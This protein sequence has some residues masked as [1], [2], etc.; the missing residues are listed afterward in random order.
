M[1]SQDADAGRVV[2]Q[3]LLGPRSADRPLL[4]AKH[5]AKHWVGVDR[6]LL[7][8]ARHVLLVR[9]AGAQGRGGVCRTVRQAASGDVSAR[10]AA[11]AAAHGWRPNA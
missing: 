6:R 5:M 4:Y 10:A 8:C 7:R 2:A 3:Q 1:A 11:A 9:C